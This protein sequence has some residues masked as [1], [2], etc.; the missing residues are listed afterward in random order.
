M[1]RSVVTAKRRSLAAASAPVPLPPNFR[2]S[3]SAAAA[4][5]CGLVSPV[6]ESSKSTSLHQF[7]RGK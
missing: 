2:N 4:A 7:P 6:A 1:R 3:A 5:G